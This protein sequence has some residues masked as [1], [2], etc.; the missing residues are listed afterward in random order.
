[1][2]II[3]VFQA[4]VFF[5]L[6]ISVQ[7]SDIEGRARI[8]KQKLAA[9]IVFAAIFGIATIQLM[10]K[11]PQHMVRFGP[12]LAVVML[13]PVAILFCI[14]VGG[15]IFLGV[16]TLLFTALV[17]WRTLSTRKSFSYIDM[18]IHKS[19]KVVRVYI[20]HTVICMIGIILSAGLLFCFVDGIN[21]AFSREFDLLGVLL[22]VSMYW[23]INVIR[24]LVGG[25]VFGT[26]SLYY[27][28]GAVNMPTDPSAKIFARVTSTVFGHMCI[29]AFLVPI[30][31]I[32]HFVVSFANLFF[33]SSSS[34]SSSS[35]PSS[36]SSSP[37]SSSSSLLLLL[38]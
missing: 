32:L 12:P 15:W 9:P 3:F 22:L 35:S 23:T 11:R 2:S 21:Y 20:G 29:G 16:C 31:E 26:A 13:L 38:F 4:V 10:R 6:S 25:I 33:S 37:S 18:V 28:K 24:F 19:M 34:S 27:Y 1:M 17:A 36:P 14:G 30:L 5:A 7:R 8:F